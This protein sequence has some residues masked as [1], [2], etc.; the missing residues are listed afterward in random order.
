MFIISWH[1]HGIQSQNKITVHPT[2]NN[3][4]KKKTTLGKHNLA[5]IPQQWPP[6]PPSLAPNWLQM[7][8]GLILASRLRSKPRPDRARQHM[9]PAQNVAPPVPPGRTLLRN[10]ARAPFCASLRLRP[11]SLSSSSSLLLAAKPPSYHSSMHILHWNSL[12]FS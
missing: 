7:V 1:L 2:T 10:S 4:K 3:G 5:I 8:D 12:A 9:T 11:S 6:I